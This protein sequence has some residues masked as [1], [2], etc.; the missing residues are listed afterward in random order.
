M[1][2]DS[3][4]RRRLAIVCTLHGVLGLGGT[5]ASYLVVRSVFGDLFSHW[6][7][8]T[9]F[10]I[11]ACTATAILTLLAY[12]AASRSLVAISSLYWSYISLDSWVGDVQG[13]IPWPINAVLVGFLA[14]SWWYVVRWPSGK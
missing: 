9:V 12:G 13:W 5:V 6:T 1:H 7:Y 14:I 8:A 2:L 11:P 3:Q 4:Q 10:A